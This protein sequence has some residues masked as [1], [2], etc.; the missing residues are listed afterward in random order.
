MKASISPLRHEREKRGWSRP[1]VEARTEGRISQVSLERWEEGKA[2]PRSDNIDELCKLYGKNPEELALVKSYDIMGT[3]NNAPTSQEEYPMS[4]LIRRSLLSDLGSHLTGLISR[5]PR[6][7][8]HYEELQ[9]E[10]NKAVTKHIAIA[11]QDILPAMNRR[12]ALMSLGLVPIQLIAETPTKKTDTDTLLTYCAAGITACWYLRRG[13]DLGFAN[14]AVS[15]YI[16]MLKP[17]IYSTS[18]AYRKASAT[19]LAQSFTLKSRLI[20]ALFDNEQAIRYEEEAIRYALMAESSTEQALANREMASLYWRCKKYKLALPYIETAYGQAKNAPRII[21]SFTASGLAVCQASSGHIEEAQI[22][23]K[24][25][26]DL[27]DPAKLIP[28]MPY[29]E[30]TLSS[31]DAV[32]YQHM[33]K[34]KEAIDIY[35]QYKEHPV[36]VLGAIQNNIEYVATEVSRDDKPRDMGLCVKLLTEAITGARELGS[37]RFKREASETFGL[38][39]IAWPREGAIKTLGRDHFGGK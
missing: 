29:G 32:I 20:S 9:T 14:D 23:L 26:H 12:Q 4:D 16:K 38:L 33:G 18:E 6:R 37:E 39:K 36:T 7:N 17:L 28:T 24:E 13:N 22:S 31:A 34:F 21:R 15:E 8:H 10:I 25:A 3:D 35:K 19:L 1:Y 30:A 11:G 27:F 5:W 2:F